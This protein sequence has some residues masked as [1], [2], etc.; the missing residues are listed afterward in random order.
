LKREE[1]GEESREGPEMCSKMA[2]E[3]KV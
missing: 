2:C 1:M 3:V